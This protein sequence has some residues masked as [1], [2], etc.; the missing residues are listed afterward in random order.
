MQIMNVTSSQEVKREFRNWGLLLLI[1]GVLSML[2]GLVF[3][4][5][6]TS[7]E[8]QLVWGQLL[9]FLPFFIYRGSYLSASL[10]EKKENPSFY[11][12]LTWFSF[13][14]FFTASYGLFIGQPLFEESFAELEERLGGAT[15]SEES[16]GIGGVSIVLLFLITLGGPILE[17]FAFRGILLSSL[18]RYGDN[19]A[20]VASAFLFG[21]VHY[22][23]YQFFLAFGA[24]IFFGYGVIRYSL[25]FS[26]LLHILNNSL[27]GFFAF[28]PG[29]YLVLLL[30][31]AIELLRI[32]RRNP[33]FLLEL[34][35]YFKLNPWLVKQFLI[36]KPI[37]LY[38]LM[39]I[40]FSWI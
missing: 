28:S 13:L 38:I 20:I 26:I 24:G 7:L 1:S 14:I 40:W 6:Q 36:S 2:S 30:F 25:R 39:V 3:R 15:S 17:E 9:I 27:G 10:R 33:L 32:W 18:R 12:G 8:M 31:V 4:Q 22:N 37:F 19:F 21:L 35:Q 16:G 29:L 11:S 5:W 34:R 23:L